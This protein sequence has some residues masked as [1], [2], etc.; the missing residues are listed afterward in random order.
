VKGVLAPAS[1]VSSSIARRRMPMPTATS[2][3]PSREGSEIAASGSWRFGSV[4]RKSQLRLYEDRDLDVVAAGA[5]EAAHAPGVEHARLARR[6]ER[7]PQHGSAGRREARL[8]AVEHEPARHEP[9]ALRDAA[10]VLEP[11]AQP[12][13]AVLGHHTQG[14]RVDRAR[15]EGARR[16]QH[17][18]D[19]AV[20]VEHGGEAEGAGADRVVPAGGAVGRGHLLD[21]R[22]A[23]PVVEPRA[24]EALGHEHAEQPGLVESVHHGGGQ[25]AFALAL[26]GV[27]PDQ[28]SE[29]PRGLDQPLDS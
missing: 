4:P 2:E 17:L 21:H 8:L 22:H 27:R 15:H 20:V 18:L 3:T 6:E 5:A 13:A 12:I 14:P 26:V 19:R 10:R 16:L 7:A 11:A 23:L 25:P 24:A 28:G 9:R 29:R 1:A